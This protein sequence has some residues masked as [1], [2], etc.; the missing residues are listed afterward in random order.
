[1]W[2]CMRMSMHACA[3]WLHLKDGPLGTLSVCICQSVS[4]HFFMFLWVCGGQ[5]FSVVL[6]WFSDMSRLPCSLSIWWL[7]MFAELWQG[8]DMKHGRA[9]S[10][11]PQLNLSCPCPGCLGYMQVAKWDSPGEGVKSHVWFLLQA[12]IEDFTPFYLGTQASIAIATEHS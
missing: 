7:M 1:M 2:L 9:P 10:K 3:R 12:P 5:R 11:K 8:A 6:F 4:A